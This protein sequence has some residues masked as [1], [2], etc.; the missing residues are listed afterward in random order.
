MQ[1]SNILI[2]LFLISNLIIY[3]QENIV[4]DF[5]NDGYNDTLIF[6]VIRLPKNIPT[7]VDLI[8]GKTSSNV[9]IELNDGFN[10]YSLSESYFIDFENFAF[11]KKLI[12]IIFSEIYNDKIEKLSSKLK[13][14]NYSQ[15]RFITMEIREENKYLDSYIRDTCFR[16]DSVLPELQ[17][18]YVLLEDF[19]E[20]SKDQ[21]C[22]DLFDE[23]VPNFDKKSNILWHFW[24]DKINIS[25]F[26]HVEINDSISYYEN[27]GCSFL[28][29]GDL[30][31]WINL[32]PDRSFWSKH[33]NNTFQPK[34]ILIGNHLFI[35][36]RYLNIENIEIINLINGNR[37]IITI[38][39][40]KDFHLKSDDVI[41]VVKYHG[42]RELIRISNLLKGW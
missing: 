29:K 3:S 13:Q 41:E 7:Y 20:L 42:S 28:K 32:T 24:G 8:D 37:G 9:H 5:N 26:A 30:Y 21:L 4:K 31:T 2:L 40:F 35:K 33:L 6:K 10:P 23:L 39:D 27:F 34:A 19:H 36:K 22:C 18:Q 38:K 17:K 12:K 15:H 1:K 11:D 16:Y 25:D 14:C